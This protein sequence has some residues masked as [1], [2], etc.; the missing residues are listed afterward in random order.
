MEYEKVSSKVPLQ[1]TASPVVSQ[2][3]ATVTSTDLGEK[4]R[5]GKK[6]DFRF[7]PFRAMLNQINLNHVTMMIVFH[8]FREAKFKPKSKGLFRMRRGKSSL[9]GL[10]T[11]YESLTMMGNFSFMLPNQKDSV[12]R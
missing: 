2:P 12:G 8:R 11:S 4:L 6:R 3:S 10:L 9:K 5:V 1:H 7:L